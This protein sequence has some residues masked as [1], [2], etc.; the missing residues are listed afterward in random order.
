MPRKRFQLTPSVYLVLIKADKILLSRRFNT[1]Y[2]DNFYSL[3]A[4]HLDGNET[5]KQAMVREAKEEIDISLDHKDL[6]LVHTMNRKIPD[7]EKIDFFFT[8]KKWQGK[9]KIMEPNKCN[10]LEWF[11]IN[12]SPKEIIPYIKQAIKSISKNVSYSEREDKEE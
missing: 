11:D 5:L 8:S 4:G 10:K 3:P 7:D 12:N 1:G 9:P 2:F 6:E